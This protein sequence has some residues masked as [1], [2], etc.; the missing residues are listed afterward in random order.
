MRPAQLGPFVERLTGTDPDEPVIWPVISI[1]RL[2][3]CQSM[4]AAFMGC[5]G[6]GQFVADGFQQR[7]RQL[8]SVWFSMF[9]AFVFDADP[10]TVRV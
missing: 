1:C 7:F 4:F 9:R 8:D 3:P 5:L 6:S 2:M 10:T